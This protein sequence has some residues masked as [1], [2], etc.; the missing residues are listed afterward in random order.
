MKNTLTTIALNASRTHP[1]GLTTILAGVAILGSPTANA[2]LFDEESFYQT[3]GTLPAFS[4]WSTGHS[5]PFVTPSGIF[6]FTASVFQTLPEDTIQFEYYISDPNIL[7]VPTPWE[8]AEQTFWDDAFGTGGF[9]IDGQNPYVQDG[10]IEASGWT[11]LT[12]GPWVR[13]WAIKIELSD[14]TWEWDE[15]QQVTVSG[16]NWE[17]T[18][19]LIFEQGN[20][21]AVPDGGGSLVLLGFGLLGLAVVRR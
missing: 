1:V 7:P 16:V 11:A 6:S 19:Q 2:G 10:T 13:V 5:A 8:T 17:Y 14:L 4:F 21:N 20:P 12:F 15:A 9:P 3:G 18:A